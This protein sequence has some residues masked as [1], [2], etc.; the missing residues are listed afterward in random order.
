MI[1]LILVCAS[2]SLLNKITIKLI[3]TCCSNTEGRYHNMGAAEGG[4]GRWSTLTIADMRLRADEKW[5]RWRMVTVS[6][7]PLSCLGLDTLPAV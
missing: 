4:G 5:K 1:G 6:F 7:S 2:R 3:S